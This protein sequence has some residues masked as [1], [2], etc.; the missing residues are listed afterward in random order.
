M[1][2][3]TSSIEKSELITRLNAM[4]ND[5]ILKTNS[6]TSHIDKLDQFKN[7]FENNNYKHK[8]K[9]VVKIL[10]SLNH[11]NRLEIVLLLKKGLICSCELE[12]ILNL[13]QPTISHHLKILEDGGIISINKVGK[14]NT[15]QLIET[16]VIFWLLEKLK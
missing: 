14:W 8:E 3:S 9:S 12:Y 16:P 11:P 7:D 13:S 4:K 15:I 2:K 1:M 6:C 10:K 5:G